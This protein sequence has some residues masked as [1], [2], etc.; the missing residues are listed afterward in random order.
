MTRRLF[1]L[2][3]S[4]ATDRLILAVG[5]KF[6]KN[7]VAE[8]LLRE[9]IGYMYSLPHCYFGPALRRLLVR[10][11]GLEPVA[12]MP[13]A[14]ASLAQPKHRMYVFRKGGVPHAG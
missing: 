3:R 12:E 1:R 11:C 4:P 10:E 9:R 6:H 13:L 14:H 7:G 8:G 2:I 5:K